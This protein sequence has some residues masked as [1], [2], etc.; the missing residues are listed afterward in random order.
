MDV[1]VRN[2]KSVEMKRVVEELSAC[3]VNMFRFGLISAYWIAV[4]RRYWICSLLT[5][6]SPF[7]MWKYSWESLNVAPIKLSI[8][9][10]TRTSLRRYWRNG[11]ECRNSTSK[12]YHLRN[13]SASW[14]TPKEMNWP[15]SDEPRASADDCL[16]H[17]LRFSFQRG[18]ALKYFNA[19]S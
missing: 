18:S 12:T 7:T 1:S 4:K 13:K 19:A 11:I 5:T 10:T 15:L 14:R 2:R 9:S 3:T 8:A 6:T 17:S 16:S